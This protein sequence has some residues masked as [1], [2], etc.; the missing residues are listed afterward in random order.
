MNYRRKAI[1]KKC[2]SAALSA[3]FILGTAAGVPDERKAAAATMTTSVLEDLE[4]Y[5]CIAKDKETVDTF[6]VY[7]DGTD[8]VVSY[9]DNSGNTQT[10]IIADSN[11]FIMNSSTALYIKPDENITLGSIRLCGEVGYPSKLSIAEGATLTVSEIAGDSEDIANDIY[12]FG[13]LAMDSFDIGDL[14]GSG[15]STAV[16]GV[17]EADTIILKDEGITSD[18]DAVYRA[19]TAFSKD[20]FDLLGTVEVSSDTLIYSEGGSFTISVDG[21]EKTITGLVLEKAAG[22]LMKN[23]LSVTLDPIDDVYVGEDYDFTDHVHFTPEDFD[24]DWEFVYSSRSGDSTETTTRPNSGSIGWYRVYV[25]VPESD[26]YVSATS[27]SQN[28]DVVYYPFTSDMKPGFTDVANDIYAKDTVTIVPPEGYEIFVYCESMIDFADEGHLTENDLFFYD[29]DGLRVPNDDI[30]YALRNKESGATIESRP[31]MS[32][33]DGLEQVIFDPDPP[34][35]SGDPVVDGEEKNIDEGEELFA[36]KVEIT[37]MDQRLYKVET[38]EKTYTI[39]NGGITETDDGNICTMVFEAEEDNPKECYF[40]AYDL[41]DNI[42]SLGF[43]LT[44]PRDLKKSVTVDIDDINDIYVGKDYDLSEYVHLSDDEYDGEL[45]YL[46]YDGVI[47]IE[48]PTEFGTY[49]FMVKGTETDSYKSVESDKVSFNIAF[50]PFPSDGYKL[51]GLKND[52]YTEDSFIISAPS[53]YKLKLSEA[54]VFTDS[55]TVTKEML[56]PEE[57]GGEVNSDLTITLKRTSDNALTDSES[58]ASVVTKVNDV[59]FDSDSPAISGKPLADGKAVDISEGDEIVAETVEI[60]LEDTSLIKVETDEKTYT[61]DDGTITEG[62]GKNSVKLSFLAEEGDPKDCSFTAYDAFGKTM[63]LSFVLKHPK[64]EEETTED[65][66]EDTGD[67]EDTEDTEDTGDPTEDPTEEPVEKKDA[68]LRIVLADQYYGVVYSPSVETESDGAARVSFTY[69]KKGSSSDYTTTKPKEPGDYIVRAVVP[70]TAEYNETAAAAEFTI[71]YLP[72]PEEPYTIEGKK[73][74]NQ[75]YITDVKLIAKKNYLIA[76][77]LDGD[78]QS[79]ILY[80]DDLSA[81]CLMRTSDGARTA[82]IRYSNKLKVDKTLPGVSPDSKDQDGKI[83]DISQDLFADMITVTVYDENLEKV[84]VNGEEQKITDKKA[85]L[86][87]YA[88]GDLFSYDIEAYDIAG[89]K[90]TQTINIYAS[91]MRDKLIPLGSQVLLRSGSQYRLG[92]GKWKVNNDKT[93]YNGGGGI[94]VKKSGEYKFD[95]VD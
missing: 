64:D 7:K 69:K 17:V 41:S 3:A 80:S 38:S 88:K 48:K 86:R 24:G 10:Q 35:Y 36:E 51:I 45:S 57:L 63:S 2:L 47:A 68:A 71:R 8:Q 15:I 52:K 22:S 54:S 77:K 81:V 40:I 26:D 6:T 61:F 30:L 46:Y 4:N 23:E 75:Y 19:E 78:Y 70:E 5:E 9:E 66:T 73:G 74:E 13:T 87:L 34:F 28:Y 43:S 93:I 31:L 82:E 84:M 16:V 89:N 65:T 79:S 44:H 37:V 39:A 32:D 72:M 90:F 92:S 94:Y 25:R 56:Y 62:S 14:Y 95:K 29:S 58:L 21:V 1:S 91:W 83:V 11:T 53:G 50:L 49:D 18:S 76:D 60:T 33:V 12:V 55:A 85:V 27:S 20:D 59:V 42:H 67:T